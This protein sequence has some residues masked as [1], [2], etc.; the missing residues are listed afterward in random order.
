MSHMSLHHDASQ[1]DWT[2]QVTSYV[3]GAFNC[4]RI[5]LLLK[6]WYLLPLN[7]FTFDYQ[8]PKSD[9]ARFIVEKI[10][11]QYITSFILNNTLL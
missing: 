4:F 1:D 11:L 10:L 3:L 8:Y 6:F 7:L 9:I 5:M 2:F